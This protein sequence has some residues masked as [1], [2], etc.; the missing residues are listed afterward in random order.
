MFFLSNLPVA[1][2][3]MVEFH[4]GGNLF[5][6]Q[7]LYS[8]RISTQMTMLFNVSLRYIN[9]ILHPFNYSMKHQSINFLRKRFLSQNE[10]M[11]NNLKLKTIHII[12]VTYFIHNA[13]AK[14]DINH[15]STMHY[16]Q[17]YPK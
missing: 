10:Q 12:L 5:L 15:L 1:I 7:N 14:L 6:I 9:Q 3:E 17:Q 8:I 13:N 11:I 16:V 2:C 4:I